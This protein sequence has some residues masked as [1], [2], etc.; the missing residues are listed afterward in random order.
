MHPAVKILV[1]LIVLLTLGLLND[2]V[3][4]LFF[5][6]TI[7]FAYFL[8]HKIFALRCLQLKWFILSIL[9]VYAF[10]TPG[11]YLINMPWQYL[12]TKEGLYLGF[13]QVA[14]LLLAL[15]LLSILFY[16]TNAQQLMLGLYA[17]LK[18][19]RLLN[20]D[21][22]RFVVRLML[23]LDYVDQFTVNPMRKKHFFALLQATQQPIAAENLQTIQIETP[24]L[25]LTDFIVILFAVIYS[26]F[27]LGVGLPS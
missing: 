9:L 24:A 27:V 21:A 16:Q 2:S 22:S 13:L 12:P 18:P 23:T 7:F 5:M 14:R 11:E 3:F 19:L 15:S 4:W 17:L 6:V 26:V 25:K 8:Q 20:I 1:Y 10:G